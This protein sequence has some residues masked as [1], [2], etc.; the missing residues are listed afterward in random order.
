MVA[1]RFMH[2]RASFTDYVTIAKCVHMRET[3]R[4]AE[5][6]TL[7]IRYNFWPSIVFW[8]PRCQKIL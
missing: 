6:Q 8:L 5:R 4:G 2:M 3:E 1:F 7:A